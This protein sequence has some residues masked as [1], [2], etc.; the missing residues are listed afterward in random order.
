[1]AR[2]TTLLTWATTYEDRSELNA[3]FTTDWR[4]LVT[5]D[6]RAALLGDELTESIRAWRRDPS[7]ATLGDFC[8]VLINRCASMAAAAVVA[9]HERVEALEADDGRH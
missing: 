4:C 8:A 7:D 3:Y 6:E 1:M 5:N 2:Q 9:L